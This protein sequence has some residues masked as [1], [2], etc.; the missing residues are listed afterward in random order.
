MPL[1][2]LSWRLKKGQWVRIWLDSW[3][4]SGHCK[5]CIDM[6]RKDGFIIDKVLTLEHLVEDV[7]SHTHQSIHLGG[8]PPSDGFG[9]CYRTKHAKYYSNVI[10]K[11][12]IC[13]KK[14]PTQTNPNLQPVIREVQTWGAGSRDDWQINNIV[15]LRAT[16]N[17]R[18][19]LVSVN[20]FT[21]FSLPV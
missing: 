14:N 20:T 15:V 2:V 17:L 18:Y 5:T 7:I 9:I 13:A 3:L 8:M 1:Q 19:S 21:S 11:I 4:F 6:V 12:M 10:Q 16:R